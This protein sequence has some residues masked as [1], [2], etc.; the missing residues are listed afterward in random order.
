[1][2]RDDIV[3][4]LTVCLWILLSQMYRY[5]TQG[6]RAVVWCLQGLVTKNV[7]VNRT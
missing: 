7:W 5:M 1:M 2:D 4:N 6:K 3:S